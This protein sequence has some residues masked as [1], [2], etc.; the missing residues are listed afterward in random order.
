MAFVWKT[1]VINHQIWEYNTHCWV[2]L[3]Q[4]RRG[5]ESVYSVK[6]AK[7][8]FLILCVFHPCAFLSKWDDVII[9]ISTQLTQVRRVVI[10][11]PP[12]LATLT[13][14]TTSMVPMVQAF[15][16][17]HVGKSLHPGSGGGRCWPAEPIDSWRHGRVWLHMFV[18]PMNKTKWCCC[19]GF[20]PKVCLE[21]VPDQIW[22]EEPRMVWISPSEQVRFSKC[23]S[24]PTGF[25]QRTT[26][27]T[28]MNDASS[29]SHCVGHLVV[30]D[31]SAW[32]K[33]TLGK[34]GWRF[35]AANKASLFDLSG[36]HDLLVSW[37]HESDMI[38]LHPI[39]ASS[40]R[41]PRC[42]PF[43]CTTRIPQTVPG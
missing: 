9:I 2:L 31:R 18:L 33:S 14:L 25:A 29:R 42:L 10:P 41:C 24:R 28:A 37:C 36:L 3:R 30:M 20:V 27:A 17:G 5:K 35:A 38:L 40:D 23:S 26:S 43:A 6:S 4:T 7:W 11:F 1:V 19:Y 32:V 16:V 13:T 22:S 39:A 15:S 8:Q 21:L 12:I 34:H